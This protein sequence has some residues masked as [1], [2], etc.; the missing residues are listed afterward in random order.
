MTAISAIPAGLPT[1]VQI[2]LSS[3]AQRLAD[4]KAVVKN[5]TDVET[6]GSTS[7]INSDK[8]GTLTLNQMTAT[9]MFTGGQWYTIEGNGYEKQG[10]ILH[11]AGDESPDFTA[12]GL[13]AGPVQRRHGRRRRR[14]WSATR[15]RPRSWSSPRRLG[16]DAETRARELPRLAEV[17][18]D[19]AY[20]FMATF[21]RV[22]RRA[23]R[24]RSSSW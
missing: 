19:S 15:P 9:T 8:T 20:K 16:V 22:P 5:L 12:L 23:T 6:L 17:P 11:A 14:P 4:A 24:T 1:F 10:A 3:G 2:M 13:R 21:H 7:A 18:F